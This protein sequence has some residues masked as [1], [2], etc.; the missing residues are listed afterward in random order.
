MVTN[1][2]CVT[3]NFTSLARWKGLF[4]WFNAVNAS[5]LVEEEKFDNEN[6]VTDICE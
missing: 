6:T 4:V 2:G 5:W 1:L 3:A